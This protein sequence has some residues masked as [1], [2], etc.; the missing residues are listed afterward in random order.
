MSRWNRAYQGESAPCSALSLLLVVSFAL[1]FASYVSPFDSLENFLVLAKNVN[2]RVW[3]T[4]T[5][6]AQKKPTSSVFRRRQ[7]TGRHWRDQS[8][9]SHT[10]GS[11]LGLRQQRRRLS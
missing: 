11:S 6:N 3:T 7:G 4:V 8:L 2:I 10:N 5:V 9:L 1:D